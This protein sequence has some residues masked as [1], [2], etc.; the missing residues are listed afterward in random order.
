MKSFLSSSPYRPSRPS[1]PGESDVRPDG[2]STSRHHQSRNP[3]LTSRFSTLVTLLMVLLVSSLVSA[4]AIPDDSHPLAHGMFLSRTEVDDHLDSHR[5]QEGQSRYGR[6]WIIESSLTDEAATLPILV[7][8]EEDTEEH[9]SS[10]LHARSDASTNSLPTAFDT[11]LSNNFT[12]ESCPKFFNA[13]LSNS[14]VTSCYPISLLLHDSTSFFHTL[15]SAT[16]TSHVLDLSCAASV[17]TCTSI[18]NRLATNLLKDDA[19]GK[20]YKLGNPLVASAYTGFM[21]YEPVYRASC[22]K[23]PAT[24][25]YCFVD[26]ATNASS[27]QDLDTYSIPAGYPT[28]DAPWPTCN[29]CLQASMDIFSRWAQVDGQ[30]LTTSY[31]PSAMALNRHCGPNFANVN[32]TVGEK[33]KTTSG[34]WGPAAVDW[35]LVG[36]TVA[37]SLGMSLL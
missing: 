27:P 4:A 2:C 35:R 30:P 19:C 26:A 25:D 28:D 12:A 32:I 36:W 29:K 33:A 11:N 20:D 23:N 17:D 18:F 3:K 34:A 10:H 7:A 15:T 24:N 13:F 5:A 14:T 37:L 1:Q 8:P 6:N 9:T 16:A 21:T 31:L 22:L